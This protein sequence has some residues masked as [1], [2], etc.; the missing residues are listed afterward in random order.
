MAI[1]NP[2]LYDAVIAGATAVNSAWLSDP[3]SADYLAVV[4]AS[5]KLAQA[6]D[7]D[8]P[9]LTTGPSLSEINL[10]LGITVNTLT[11]RDIR[12]ITSFT[13]IAA[14][15]AALYVEGNT[16]LKNPNSLNTATIVVP[17]TVEVAGGAGA[18]VDLATYDTAALAVN[19]KL[20]VGIDASV[21]N[22]TTGGI[23][24]LRANRTYVNG[25]GGLSLLNDSTVFT[26]AV[27]AGNP[28]I[29]LAIVGNVLHLQG[30]KEAAAGATQDYSGSLYIATVTVGT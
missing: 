24:E 7:A 17:V 21:Q 19:Q 4:T 1:N 6:V 13:A 30:W 5:D 18:Y 10:L 11:G 15:I 20:E 23:T 9:T 27:I 28:A 26:P 3:V 16:K 8:I 22:Q 29:Q 12:T 25:G 14:A 2:S